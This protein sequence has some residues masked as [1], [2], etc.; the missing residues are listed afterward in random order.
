M[1]DMGTISSI[2]GIHTDY[3]KSAKQ[4][5]I[6][7]IKYMHTLFDTFLKDDTVTAPTPIIETLSVYDNDQP[8]DNRYRQLLGGLLYLS[9]CTRPDIAYATSV[10]SRYSNDPKARH[11]NAAIRVLRYLKQHQTAKLRLSGKDNISAFSDADWAS[12]PDTRHSTSGYLIFLGE[13]CISWKSSRQ[14]I[15]AL[16]STEAEYIAAALACQDIIFVL[17]LAQELGNNI[18]TPIHLQIDNTSTISHITNK[19]NKH[20]TTK[21]M[22]V[23]LHFIRDLYSTGL[24]KPEH[25][26]TN[27]QTADILTKP[28][29]KPTFHKHCNKFM[30]SM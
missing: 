30:A 23:R 16:S 29:P 5:H 8:A 18:T 3:N 17:N 1:K 12:D 7:Q 28:L 21:H 6:D 13:S 11:W 9:V 19:A 10:L 2:L 26:S 25:V 15:T 14:H 22:D 20:A 24:I 4:I 27:N